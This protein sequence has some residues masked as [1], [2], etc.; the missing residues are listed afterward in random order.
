MVSLPQL[1]DHGFWVKVTKP[2]SPS[3]LSD[4]EREG[5][6]GRKIDENT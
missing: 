3:P 2:V 1:F 4:G 5:V 6:R